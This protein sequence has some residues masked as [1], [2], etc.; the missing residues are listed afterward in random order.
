[1]QYKTDTIVTNKLIICNMV[2]NNN[3]TVKPRNTRCPKPRNSYCA[4]FFFVR[5][6]LKRAIAALTP[7]ARRFSKL[8][9][10]INNIITIETSQNIL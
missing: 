7:D 4:Q 3:I 1:M 8:L 10:D 9:L 5:A 2:N 6:S